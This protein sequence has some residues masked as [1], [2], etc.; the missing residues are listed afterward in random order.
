MQKSGLSEIIR[1]D[2]HLSY[3]GPIILLSPSYKVPSGCTPRGAVIVAELDGHQ[4]P[5]LTAD[6]AGNS[7]HSQVIFHYIGQGPVQGTWGIFKWDKRRVYLP[8][9]AT[10]NC[11][12]CGAERAARSSRGLEIATLSVWAQECYLSLKG[13]G[14][15][16]Q[17]QTWNRYLLHSS[18]RQLRGK[19]WGDVLYLL[20]LFSDL[21]TGVP[22]GQ[23][24]SRGH[25]NPSPWSK[26]ASPL[27]QRAGY[28]TG[29][30]NGVLPSTIIKS[31]WRKLV[32][33]KKKKYQ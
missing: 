33:K 26:Q 2:R 29:G 21:L 25:E 22:I 3:L 1:F 32:N 19:R 9:G 27:G 16:S 6:V 11:K 18:L 20:L 23:T 5:F 31:I 12:L 24:Q 10:T 30:A 17:H 13:G 28:R 7:F 4:H 15:K 8:K 14:E